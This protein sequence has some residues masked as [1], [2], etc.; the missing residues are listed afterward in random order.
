MR[1]QDQE[2][3]YEKRNAELLAFYTKVGND[4]RLCAI[5][6]KAWIDYK[7]E[8]VAMTLDSFVERRIRNYDRITQ[9]TI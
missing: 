8:R 4:P 6:D 9:K 2:L 5:A 3:K 1:N 7:K